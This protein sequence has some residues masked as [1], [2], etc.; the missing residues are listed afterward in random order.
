MLRF[1]II[2]MPLAYIMTALAYMF[3]IDPDPAGHPS[4]SVGD[5]FS[6]PHP[7]VP[8]LGVNAETQSMILPGVGP[9]ARPAR[10][11]PAASAASAGIRAQ[12][13]AMKVRPPV[14]SSW[15]HIS[16]LYRFTMVIRSPDENDV[17]GVFRVNSLS[18]FT[19][20][21]AQMLGMA[22]TFMNFHGDFSDLHMFV[23]L[24]MFSQLVNWSITLLFYATSV[25]RTMGN[26]I[27]V[28]ALTSN[29]S[30]SVQDQTLVFAHLAESKAKQVARDQVDDTQIFEVDEHV[31]KVEWEVMSMKNLKIQLDHFKPDEVDSI[32]RTLYLYWAE[33]YAR[34]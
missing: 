17:E 9:P 28:E 15:G 5:L 20:G 3:L 4:C 25:A 18:S 23:Y 6:D 24:N 10:P 33:E 22:F 13:L 14:H 11:E 12:A 27:T 29:L 1:F 32:R 7:V 21:T 2:L 16:P 19:L 30:A 26:Q 31:K 8:A 34:C